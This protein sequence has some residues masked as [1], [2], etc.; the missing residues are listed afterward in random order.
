MRRQLKKRPVSASIAKR[1]NKTVDLDLIELIQVILIE[2]RVLVRL[3]EL[4]YNKLAKYRDT[5]QDLQMSSNMTE[6]LLKDLVDFA[7]I[8]NDAFHLNED[9]FD[10]VEVV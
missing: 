3:A 4:A 9:Y 1:Q 6:I 10:L 5:V 8:K 2:R 7:M